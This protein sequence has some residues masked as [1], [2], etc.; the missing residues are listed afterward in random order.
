MDK[1]L[2]SIL[3]VIGILVILYLSLPLLI[4]FVMLILGFS[5]CFD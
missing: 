4:T 1:L 5:G 2:K 3:I